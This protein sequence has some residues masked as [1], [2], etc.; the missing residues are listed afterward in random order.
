LGLR[1][2][3]RA[4]IRERPFRHE[5]IAGDGCASAEPSSP[6]RSN[7]ARQPAAIPD[8]RENA[9]ANGRINSAGTDGR[10]GI[11]CPGVPILSCPRSSTVP[12]TV[13]ARASKIDQP[14][15]NIGRPLGTG[16]KNGR[17]PPWCPPYLGK[18]FAVEVSSR[19]QHPL[20]P[21]ES[22]TGG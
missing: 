15:R 22:I 17:K 12:R 20:L 18:G 16:R 21:E 9:A 8:L 3:H 19:L 7:L 4:G 2:H 5:P 1:R 11:A 13:R 14:A 6:P 10:A